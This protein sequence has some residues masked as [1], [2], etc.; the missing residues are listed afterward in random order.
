MILELDQE[1]FKNYFTYSLKD[2]DGIIHGIRFRQS[3]NVE[4]IVSISEL[5]PSSITVINTYRVVDREICEKERTFLFDFFSK[6]GVKNVSFPDGF[7]HVDDF[8]SAANLAADLDTY[9]TIDEG[10]LGDY[11][12]L[13]TAY[14]IENG[15]KTLIARGILPRGELE[16]EWGKLIPYFEFNTLEFFDVY[17]NNLFEYVKGRPATKL[18]LLR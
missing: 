9:L 13:E 3:N 8:I 5:I 4:C 15:A 2:H 1:S 7:N 6:T 17:A 12:I 10:E 16:E 18:K 14:K 11:E